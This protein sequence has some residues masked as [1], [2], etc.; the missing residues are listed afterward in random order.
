MLVY[1]WKTCSEHGPGMKKDYIF[2]VLLGDHGDNSQQTLE[3]STV[4]HKQ[5]HS[6]IA[7]WW[8]VWEIV[9]EGKINALSRFYLLSPYS[10]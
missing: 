5:R 10:Y 9:G 2:S 6:S 7:R 1:S 3:I 8:Q 4:G